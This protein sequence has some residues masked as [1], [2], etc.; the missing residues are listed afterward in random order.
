LH[1]HVGQ[2]RAIGLVL[3][4]QSVGAHDAAQ[5]WAGQTTGKVRR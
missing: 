3:I 1:R 5:A 2:P 4:G